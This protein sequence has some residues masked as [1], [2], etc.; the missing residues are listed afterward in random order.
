MSLYLLANPILMR[1]HTASALCILLYY[2]AGSSASVLE[3]T[4]VEKEQVTSAVSYATENRPSTV[5][6]ISLSSV[7]TESLAK[8]EARF[9]ELLNETAAKELD[10]VYLR[11]SISRERRRIKFY[12]ESSLSFFTE[13]IIQ[14]FLFGKRDGS[15]LRDLETMREYDI[16]ETWTDDQWR[17]LLR[18]WLSDAHHVTILGRPSAA[19]SHKLKSDEEARVAKQIEDLGPEGLK[20]LE[21]RLAEA[22]ADNDKEIP[23]EIFDSFKVP[24]TKSIHFIPTLTARSGLARQIGRLENPIQKVIDSETADLPL[25]IHFEHVQTNFVHITL[26]MGTESVPVP[27]RPLLSIYIGSFFNLPIIRN[28]KRIDFEQV[29]MDL[30][31]DTVGYGIES[32][33]GLGNPE[34]LTVQLQLEAEK[35]PTAIQWLKDLLFGSIFDLT[36]CIPSLLPLEPQ[37]CLLIQSLLHRESKPLQNGSWQIYPKKNAT[38]TT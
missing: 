14:D 33:S 38:A 4:L 21:Q 11:D 23:N 5:I 16:L 36:V 17:E 34:V 9:F 30:E 20:K 22:K 27:L 10:M 29:I 1:L 15:T 3:N 26:I 19:L 25:F 2:L 32:G 28:G 35:Y 37:Q 13:Q 6:E 31:K 18:K 7:A 24:D 12:A 8:V